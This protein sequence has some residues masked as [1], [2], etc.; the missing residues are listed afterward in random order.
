MNT[1]M[2]N[3]TAMKWYIV[4]SQAN[5]ERSVSE[6]LVKES[7]KGSLVGK[8][9]QVIVPMEKTVSIKAG[10]KVIREKIMYPGYIFV[11]VSAIGE[12]T[13]F[14]KACDG[15]IGLL[16]SK[17]GQIQS[18]P[19]AEVQRMI[20]VSKDTTEVAEASYFVV[21]QEVKITDGPFTTFTGII[22]AIND[23]RVKISVLI[24]GRKTLVD[25]EMNQIDRN[26]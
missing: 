23:Q 26:I 13:H 11:E 9:G 4:R 14:V 6:K 22:E 17:S 10:K 18:I 3:Q 1:I 19:S 16:S 2:E 12:L 15:A 7:E 25:L 24:F 21:G 20:G 8:I 5:R